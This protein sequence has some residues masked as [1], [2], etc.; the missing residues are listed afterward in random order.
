MGQYGRV[1]VPRVRSRGL[2]RA[3]VALTAFAPF[4]AV[5]VS[6][7]GSVTVSSDAATSSSRTNEPS[8]DGIRAAAIAYA[9]AFLTGSSTDVVAVLDPGCIP[10][11][12]TISSAQI[13]DFD[14]EL[15]RLR[16]GLTARAGIEPAA[17][18]IRGVVVRNFT[19]R[20]GEAE[21]QYSLPVEA[22]GN[23]NWNSYALSEG[24][25]HIAGCEIHWPIGGSSDSGTDSTTP[26]TV[27][28]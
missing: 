7:G 4:F 16:E 9:N 21:V 25:W 23:D 6:C 28:P 24:H 13:A 27:A 8:E 12:M 20:A 26:R 15:E 14:A 5:G 10:T 22:T 3:S 1:A 19:G 2:C 17:I 18:E 11:G